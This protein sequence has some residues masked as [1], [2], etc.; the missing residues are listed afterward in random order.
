MSD[1]LEKMLVSELT[2]IVPGQVGRFAEFI[3]SRLK[4]R[5]LG[6][7]FYG[8]VLRKVDPEGILDFYVITDRPASLNGN[9]LAIWANQLL[10]PNVYYMEHEVGGRVMRAKVAFL[11]SRQFRKRSTIFSVDTTI[12]ARFCQ[13]V[14]LVWVRDSVSADQILQSVRQCVV[15]A[16]CWAA[17]LGPEK[18]R[19]ADY[20]HHLFA[21]TY[22]VE[23]RV[24]KKG[25]SYNL[26]QGK[27][28]RY[29]VMLKEAWL[30]ASLWYR[31]EGDL[32][33]PE[34]TA[35]AKSKARKN[36]QTIKSCGKPL[37][38]IRL[39]KA[40]FTFRDGVSYLL[41]KIRRHTGKE[42]QVSAFERKHPILTLPLFL[43]RARH[44]RD[45]RQ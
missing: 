27:E 12:W 36:W 6:V 18:G 3:V 23:L 2:T 14:R 11:S 39:I 9:H 4:Q 42:I 45:S 41:W 43:W 24:E 28:D 8:S 29:A 10:P 1:A 35:T 19:A 13:P 37:N 31:K 5:P 34:L 26:L 25:R 16:S 15:T 30:Q 33:H 44:V 22:E 40:A 17:L 7:L 21:C 32:L 38:V 20:W